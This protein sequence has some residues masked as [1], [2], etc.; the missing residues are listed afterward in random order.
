MRPSVRASSEPVLKLGQSS[1][2]LLSVIRDRHKA[3]AMAAVAVIN[4]RAVIRLDGLLWA[5]H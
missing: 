3:Q 1:A 5:L 4:N 2:L